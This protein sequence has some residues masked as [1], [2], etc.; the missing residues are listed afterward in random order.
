[1]VVF[2]RARKSFGGVGNRRRGFELLVEQ[3]HHERLLHLAGLEAE[4][5]AAALVGDFADAIDHVQ[6][7]GHAAVGAA[8]AIVDIVDEQRH[9]DIQHLAALARHVD[10]LTD[11]RGLIDGGA[12]F[13]FEFHGPDA[14][15][16]MRFANVNGHEFDLVGITIVQ[17]FED[18]KLGPEGASRETAEDQHHRSFVSILR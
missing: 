3:C 14:V 13:H 9:G 16:R 8:N 10:A 12:S 4:R 2:C 17:I 1:V 11:N 18:P 5:T 15:A 7:I 6:P